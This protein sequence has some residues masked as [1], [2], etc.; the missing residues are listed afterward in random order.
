M[1]ATR[2]PRRMLHILLVALMLSGVLSLAAS[3]AQAAK[4]NQW[5]WVANN[6]NGTYAQA[7]M[8][9]YE[10]GYASGSAGG[11]IAIWNG[12]ADGKCTFVQF[13]ASTGA[14]WHHSTRKVCSTNRTGWSIFN[15][16]DDFFF[17]TGNAY[18]FR[19]CIEDWFNNTCSKGVNIS[20]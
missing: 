10:S 19:V 18:S 16:A 13:K 14:V 1:L 3:D 20:A 15:W 12:R 5:Y 7:N 11:Q 2:G 8:T 17:Y 4:T 9:Y 6:F